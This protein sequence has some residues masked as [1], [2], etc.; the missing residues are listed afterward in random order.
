MKNIL[1]IAKNA[2]IFYC[3]IFTLSTL[4]CTIINLQ[5]GNYD[6]ILYTHIMIRG[7]VCL[8][9]MVVFILGDK[10]KFEKKILTYTIP[11]VIY[12]LLVFFTTWI[13]GLFTDIKGSNVYTENFLIIIT[14]CVVLAVYHA[15][16]DYRLS[17]KI[18]G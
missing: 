2:A 13:L 6:V 10:L 17:K 4:I 11:Y 8:I 7:I 9:C 12:V 5:S 3:V 16:N 1:N 15:I 18:E 14:V